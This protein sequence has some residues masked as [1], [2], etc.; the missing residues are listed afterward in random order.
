MAVATLHRGA[1]ASH[2]HG[3][4]CCGAQAPDAQAQQLWVTGLFAPRHVGSSQTRAR[5]RVPCIGRQSL[6]HCATRE[7]PRS[8]FNCISIT[9]NGFGDCRQLH[10]CITKSQ[11][12]S[13]YKMMLYSL[14]TSKTRNPGLERR[15]NLP[16]ITRFLDSKPSKRSPNY[17]LPLELLVCSLTPGILKFSAQ[18]DP[19]PLHSPD[20]IH[21]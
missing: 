5:T 9:A 21:R 10:L 18:T 20:D 12:G 15:S 11:M 19:M 8:I 3:L 7:A 2:Y 14:S 1:W 6:N 16:K 13:F 17:L 4:S